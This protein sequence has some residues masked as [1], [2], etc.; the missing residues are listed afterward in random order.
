MTLSINE[1]MV[2]N[3]AYDSNG[4]PNKITAIGNGYLQF[5][6]SSEKVY[7]IKPIKLS[8]SLMKENKWK[9]NNTGVEIYEHPNKSFGVQILP[10]DDGFILGLV[11]NGKFVNKYFHLAYL[12]QL[13]QFMILAGWNE[14]ANKFVFPQSMYKPVAKKTT[15][16]TRSNEQI[17][18]DIMT[19]VE[20][21]VTKALTKT[22]AKQ[23]L[24]V[25]VDTSVNIDDLFPTIDIP[26]IKF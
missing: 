18:R 1:F 9:R 17:T 24:S 10:N 19:A 22:V 14:L 7:D 8:I 20:D 21:T 26:E 13:Q 15:P 25:K 3:Y 4:N 12:H 6:G 16:L 2:G 11:S 5:E 23:P